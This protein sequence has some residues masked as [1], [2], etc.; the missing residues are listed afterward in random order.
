M[1]RINSRITLA[2]GKI[3]VKSLFMKSFGGPL[4]DP[5]YKEPPLRTDGPVDFYSYP[6]RAK[7]YIIYKFQG[8]GTDEDYYGQPGNF[9]RLLIPKDRLSLIENIATR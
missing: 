6:G 9:V 1:F 4:P 2:T 8:E 5:Q 7:D 3:Q